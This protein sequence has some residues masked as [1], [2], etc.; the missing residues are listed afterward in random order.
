MYKRPTPGDDLRDERRFSSKIVMVAVLIAAVMAISCFVIVNDTEGSD[1]DTYADSVWV[2]GVE[3]TPDKIYH[4]TMGPTYATISYDKTTGTLTLGDLYDTDDPVYVNNEKMTGT[5]RFGTGQYASIYSSGSLNIVFNGGYGH[6]SYVKPG[7]ITIAASDYGGATPAYAYGIYVAGNLTITSEL[8]L[9]KISTITIGAGA[10]TTES[11][12]I[13]AT[14]NVTIQQVKQTFN[15]NGGTSAYNNAPENKSSFG[16]YGIYGGRSVT[17]KNC[18]DLNATSADFTAPDCG[19]GG[20]VK[21][22]GIYAYTDFDYLANSSSYKL[23]ATGGDIDATYFTNAAYYIFTAG[24]Y[25]DD[26]L[27]STTGSYTPTV[28]A[29]GGDIFFDK[30][31]DGYINNAGGISYGV[32]CDGSM[33]CDYNLNATGGVVFYPCF[34]QQGASSRYHADSYGVYI[35]G[36]FTGG[37][38]PFTVNATGSD[39]SVFSCGMEMN[40]D[41]NANKGRYTIRAGFVALTGELAYSIGLNMSS[42]TIIAGNGTVIDA[43]GGVVCYPQYTAGIYANEIKMS[44]N[45]TVTG[46]GGDVYRQYTSTTQYQEIPFVV[47]TGSCSNSYGIYMYSG[48]IVINGDALLKGIGGYLQPDHYLNTS[49]KTAGIFVYTDCS[50][51]GNGNVEGWGGDTKYGRG[52]DSRTDYSYGISARDLTIDGTHV[53]AIGGEVCKLKNS[54]RQW[55]N[56]GVTEGIFAKSLTITGGASVSATG[57]SINNYPKG[58]SQNAPYY[59][60][61]IGV[62][63]YNGSITVEGGSSLTVS[64]GT[65]MR[66]VGIWLTGG[67]ISVGGDSYVSVRVPDAGSPTGAYLKTRDGI[68]KGSYGVYLATNDGTAVI[69]VESGTFIAEG[70]SYAFKPANYSNTITASKIAHSG[71][72]GPSSSVTVTKNS[73]TFN[74]ISGKKFVQADSH[75]YTLSYDSNGGT[76]TM[77]SQTEV[78]G[79][80]TLSSCGFTAPVGMKFKGWCEDSDGMETIY[81]ANTSVPILGNT[82]MFAIWEPI[83]YKITFSPNGGEGSMDMDTRTYNQPYELPENEF[84]APPH[85]TFSCWSVMG[86]EED[87]GTILYIT[88]DVSIQ[89]VWEYEQVPVSFASNGG[90]GTMAPVNINWGFTYNLPSNGY[91]APEHMQFKCWSVGGVEMDPGDTITVEEEITV[92]AVWEYMSYDVS[93]INYDG[94]ELQ[95]SPVVYGQKPAYTGETPAR[96][97]T[98]QYTYTFVGWAASAGQESGIANADL[99]TVSGTTVYYAAYSKTVNKYTVIWKSQDGTQT[100]ET[101]SNVPF[102]TAPDFN[103]ADPTKAADAQYTYAFAGWSTTENQT[104]GT[105]VGSLSTVSGDAIYYAAFSETVNKYTVTWKSQ[106]GTQTLETDSNVPYGSP[107]SYDGAAPTKN[108]NAQYT[109][110]FAGWSINMNQITGTPVGGLSTVSG[111]ATYYAAFSQT[112]NTYTVRFVNHDGSVLQS[113]VLEYGDT[114]A[115]GGSTPTKA[116]DSYYTYAFDDW[117]ADITEVTG[118]ATYTATFTSTIKRFTVSF[119]AGEGSGSMDDV[120]VDAGY[121]TLPNNGFTKPLNKH[122]SCW[123]LE[124]V[125]GTTYLPNSQYEVLSDVTFYA[126]WDDH[127]HVLEAIPAVAPTCTET[128]LTEGQRCTICGDIVIAQEVVPA[129]G[130]DLVH[131][132]GQ[133]ATCTEHGWEAYDTCSRCDYTTYV[134]IPALGHD[135]VHHDA[136]APTCTEVG[137]NAYDTCSR[138]DYTTYVEIPKLGHAYSATY[139]WSADGKTCTVHIVCANDAGHNHDINATVTSSVKT[140]ATFSAKG[141][142]LYSVSSSYDGFAYAST[143][144]VADIDYEVKEQDGVKTYE[145]TVTNAATNVTA[146]FNQAKEDNG[147]VELTASTDAGSITIAFDSGAVSSIGGNTVS[148]SANVV[149]K[150]TVE[151]AELVLE[152][153]LDGATFSEGKATVAVPFTETVPE[154]KVLKV[155]FI[156]GDS[157]EEMKASYENGV[158][159]FETNHFSTYAVVFED[160]SGGNGG[161]FPIGIVI[162]VVVALA[163]IGGAVFFIVKKK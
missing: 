94:T 147:T 73:T 120:E 6:P 99:P 35:R 51:S 84:T 18:W 132:D 149:D 33:S 152:I 105:A 47:E 10:A 97:V 103:K 43:Y 101:D 48:D 128:G 17:V 68:S 130:H 81:S 28:T 155:Y 113:S 91:T 37:T 75:T 162:G 110:T 80:C 1:A 32:F 115:Y 57:R 146:L 112:V 98:P 77:S 30:D 74:N 161:G 83:Q 29:K 151:N 45:A 31:Y 124:S 153:T 93:F 89:P 72:V 87:V 67:G 24:I 119:D 63:I 82:T 108:A 7:T 40:N 41:F 88:C 64:A 22:C 157:R 150:S 55:G 106:D 118:E 104:S 42:G 107:V 79:N 78:F 126:L 122:F 44:G 11:C 4:P 19:N 14:G 143:K 90:T 60:D 56:D 123:A 76:G 66:V 71:S 23:T 140:A 39:A 142:T 92:C 49:L 95:S 163:V 133:A 109:F 52:N 53:T 121:Y 69:T 137:W 144:E 27:L 50:I 2:N 138:C 9:E 136:Q 38:Y 85:A 116:E 96:P 159:T 59:H 34:G 70:Y 8:T 139:D 12:G 86:V 125:D 15:V 16:S 61:S 141:V 62:E 156:N 21:S 129:L 131:H 154:G 135:L 3:V 54:Y 5:Y 58:D 160:E 46:H 20:L 111:D 114:P 134:E 36:G 148:M 100:L 102:G 25:A 117:D 13:K 26:D 65:S 127:V 158:V 145:D